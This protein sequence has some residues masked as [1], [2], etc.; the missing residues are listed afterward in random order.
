MKTISPSASEKEESAPSTRSP[1]PDSNQS[2]V[3]ALA[4]L[5]RRLANMK[6]RKPSL[7]GAEPT[8]S[9]KKNSPQKL[10]DPSSKEDTLNEKSSPSEKGRQNPSQLI[11]LA[12]EFTASLI[13]GTLLGLLW[14]Y[15]FAT[16]PWGLVFFLLLGFAAGIRN[17]VKFA[18]TSHKRREDPTAFPLSNENGASNPKKTNPSIN[19]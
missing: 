19:S 14:D 8:H 10:N 6:D 16:P 13:V 5:E 2:P 12:S 4:L 15:F 1:S 7:T 17:L 3:E 9:S 18:E 11:H